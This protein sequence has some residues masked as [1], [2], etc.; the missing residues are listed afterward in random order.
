MVYS[1][2]CVFAICVCVGR[3]VFCY[4]VR[5]CFIHITGL[6]LVCL[7]T[8]LLVCF[9]IILLK[10]NFL[11]GIHWFAS[12]ELRVELILLI[13]TYPPPHPTSHPLH[14]WHPSIPFIPQLSCCVVLCMYVS[15][16]L[17]CLGRLKSSFFVFFR[18]E[19][20]DENE[21]RMR[22]RYPGCVFGLCVCAC[23]CVCVCLGRVGGKR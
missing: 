7:L 3:S 15:Y 13:S 17:A 11:F 8:C 22:L 19:G 12:C 14:I 6:V 18:I 5:L 23:V 4:I 10:S 20:G 2:L 1:V 21:T 16:L 9:A